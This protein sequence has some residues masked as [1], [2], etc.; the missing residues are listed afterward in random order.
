MAINVGLR[1]SADPELTIKDDQFRAC[2]KSL[3]VDPSYSSSS[4]LQQQLDGTCSDESAGKE[5]SAD[6]IR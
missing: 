6:P 5:S 3:E 4:K 2:Q 1:Q